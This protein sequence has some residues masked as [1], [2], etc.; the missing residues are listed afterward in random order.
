M[1]T[2]KICEGEN[3]TFKNP[4]DVI[5]YMHETN[6][7]NE[8]SVYDIN[9]DDAYKKVRMIYNEIKDYNKGKPLNEQILP[10]NPFGCRGILGCL[11]V[12]VFT[13]GLGTY[14]RNN[15]NL[16]LFTGY[17]ESVLDQSNETVQRTLSAKALASLAMIGGM[18]GKL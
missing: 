6:F 8:V 9:S 3:G 7:E 18:F 11:G 16:A 17:N 12:Q 5:K 15:G 1:F 14:K 2:V 4:E 13:I 10:T